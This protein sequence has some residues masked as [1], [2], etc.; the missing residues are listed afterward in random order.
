MRHEHYGHAQFFLQLAQQQNKFGQVEGDLQRVNQDKNF[1]ASQTYQL[2]QQSEQ[3]QR[4][5]ADMT[6]HMSMVTQQNFELSNELQQ[7]LQTD[8]VLQNKLNSRSTLDEIKQKV[9]FAI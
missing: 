5:I 9:D 1:V 2:K 8:E 6:R 7:F 4:Q 3:Q